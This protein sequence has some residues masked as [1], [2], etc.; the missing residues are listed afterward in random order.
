VTSPRLA[1]SITVGVGGAVGAVVRFEIWQWRDSPKWLLVNTF[2][3]NAFGCLVL[4]A[5]LGYLSG[6]RTPVLR[7][8]AI[9]LA[10]GFTSFSFYALQG[11]TYDGAWNSVVYILVTP[12]VA[13]TAL[14]AGALITRPH[15]R[16]VETLR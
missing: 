4:G 8:A 2:G 12:V 15:T 10:C 14:A 16:S 9:G 11:V 3:I 6:T 13:V 5:A 7:A 1:E